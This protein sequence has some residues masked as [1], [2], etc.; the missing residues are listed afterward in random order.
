MSVFLLHNIP[1]L[2]VVTLRVSYLHSWNIFFFR[3]EFD[4]WL[5]LQNQRKIVSLNL[6]LVLA[7]YCIE[8]YPTPPKFF[9]SSYVSLLALKAIV[10][11]DLKSR[12]KL[13]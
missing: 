10:G 13:G 2:L 8:D 1:V 6:R 4:C 12:I 7:S 5:T 3:M 11:G 9:M